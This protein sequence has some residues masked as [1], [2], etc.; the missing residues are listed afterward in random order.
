MKISVIIPTRNR[1]NELAG[2]LE[3]L[4]KQSLN[5]DLFEILVINNGS[6]DQ[7]QEVIHAY[8]GQIRHL[9]SFYEPTPGLHMG[10]H[11]GLAEAHTDILVYTDDD[12]EAF[13]SWLEGIMEAFEDQRTVLVGGKNL[14][15]F[16]EKPPDWLLQMWLTPRKE[17]RIVGFL[18]ILD[19]GDTIREIHPHYIFGCNFSIRK[20]VLLQAEGFHPD[21]MPQE[22]IRFRG[23]G[24]SHISSYIQRHHYK[25]LYHPKASIYHNIP[26]DRMTKA[27]FC[28]RAFN[29]G[30]SDSYAEIRKN[31]GIAS[32]GK[33]PSTFKRLKQFEVSVILWLQSRRETVP[34]E[35]R[36]FKQAEIAY[37]RGKMYHRKEVIADSKLLQY[38]LQP[39]YL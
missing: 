22:L 2:T 33:L 26:K 10:R 18:S 30:I 31:G 34:W 21:G 14:P 39:H 23:D 24:E 11:R 35:C 32:F 16:G 29:Q 6:T 7:T 36:V 15:K 4:R 37:K 17:G 27:Y 1:A 19:L 12:I 13:P 20:L 9:R 38:V 8:E 5:D 25:T 28:R 3:S